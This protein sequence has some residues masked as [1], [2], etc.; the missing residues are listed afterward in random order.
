MNVEQTGSSEKKRSQF[1][2]KGPQN[3]GD[4][5]ITPIRGDLADVKLAGVFFAPHY[6]QPKNSLCSVNTAMLMESSDSDAQAVSQLIYGE[7]FAI[8]DISG[9]WVWGY[10]VTDDYVGY[11]PKSV[12]TTANEHIQNTHQISS[13]GALIFSEPSIKSSTLLRL[14][15]GS[16][17]MCQETEYEDFLK[18][19]NGF[20]H[21]RH[22]SQIGK[23][24]GDSASLAR[25]LIGAPYLWGGRS[26]DALDCS[27]LVQLVLG[28]QGINAPR[29]SDMQQILGDEIPAK[30]K[31]QRNDIIFF[32]GH[33]GIMSDGENII[34]ANAHWMQVKEEPLADVIDRLDEDGIIARRRL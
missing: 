22:V 13:R 32:P 34:H 5:R 30:A 7:S 18:V 11:V 28:L 16:H 14:P 23:V 20:V 31:L 25:D 26:G 4:K 27:G 19:S 2:L 24:D 1:H 9:D 8:L 12:L 17:I 6:A 33:V 3:S 10:C 29:D 21:K 15:M